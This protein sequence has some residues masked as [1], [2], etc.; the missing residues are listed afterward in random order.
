MTGHKHI[1]L[2]ICCAPCGAP[3]AEHLVNAGYRVTLFFCNSNIYPEKEYLKRLEEA[4]RL[5][6]IMGLE[7]E[8]NQYDHADWLKAVAG[9]EKE[10]EKGERCRKCIEYNLG[11]TSQVA[12]RL[13]I[14]RFTTTLTLSPHKVSAMIFEIGKLYPHF[15]AWDFKKQNGFSR[16]L[17]LSKEHCLYRQSYCGCEFSLQI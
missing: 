2:H 4:R 16:S 11:R 9:L 10:P 3:S 1:L 8:E 15:E 7:L 6:R 5:S 12:D 17:E 13:K 14:P